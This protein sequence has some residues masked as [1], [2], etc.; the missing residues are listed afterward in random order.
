M[1]ETYAISQLVI[2]VRRFKPFEGQNKLRMQE[3]LTGINPE[4]GEQTDVPRELITPAQLFKQRLYGESGDKAY[5]RANYVDTRICIVPNP[6]ADEIKFTH[7]HPVM[8]ALNK[9]TELVKG[10]IPVSNEQYHAITDG[11]V[12]SASEVAAF[13]NNVCASPQRREEIWE[14]FAGGDTNL[15]QK[16]KTDVCNSLNLNFDSV[17]DI[18][19]PP[20]KGMRLLCVGSVGGRSYANGYSSLDDGSGRRVGVAPV[21]PVLVSA[22]EAPRENGALPDL[23]AVMSRLAN[24]GLQGRMLELARSELQPLYQKQ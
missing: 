5:L 16:Y 10:A 12:L 18:Y 19:V 23:E 9:K 13:R 8:D 17:M 4:T 7:G 1:A 6:D 20:T 11:L 15:T 22:C 21:A 14:F 2:S 24:T 3:L